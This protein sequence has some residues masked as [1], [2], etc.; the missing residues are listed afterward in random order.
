M[1][2]SDPRKARTMAE[3]ARNPD[4]TWNGERAM[5]WLTEVMNPGHGLSVEEVAR[6][7]KETVERARDAAPP[8]VTDRP[9]GVS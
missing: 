1:S 3:A 5:S 9:S 8:V 7:A 6:I 4:G 2:G